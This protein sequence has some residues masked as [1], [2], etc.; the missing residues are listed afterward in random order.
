MD[1]CGTW[2][3]GLYDRLA[4]VVGQPQGLS[5]MMSPFFLGLGLLSLHVE[6]AGK[7]PNSRL[8]KCLFFPMVTGKLSLALKA[9]VG[10]RNPTFFA[11]AVFTV[12]P[13]ALSQ[14]CF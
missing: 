9:T 7:E 8:N 5:S 12:P 10:M 2:A 1:I 11:P 14:V 3:Q 4:G 6:A 13:L